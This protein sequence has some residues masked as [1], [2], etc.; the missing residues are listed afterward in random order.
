[1][2]KL[3]IQE[4]NKRIV[5]TGM[6]Q[7]EFAAYSHIPASTLNTWLAYERNLKF[8]NAVKLAVALNCKVE[9]ISNYKSLAERHTETL[10]IQ[11]D[12]VEAYRIELA[13]AI[14]NSPEFNTAIKLKIIS[15]IIK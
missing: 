11:S 15:L 4:V 9:D 7:R 2:G 6:T 14:M 10:T 1:M 12:A 8:K 5:A 13:E 3:K